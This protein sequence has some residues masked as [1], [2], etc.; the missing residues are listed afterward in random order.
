MSYSD[1]AALHEDTDFGRRVV[2]CAATE[3][4]D[5]PQTWANT[6]LWAVSAAPGFGDAYASA[7][8]SGVERP[9][10]DPAVITDAMILGAVQAIGGLE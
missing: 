7:L 4:A 2:A 10:N 5:N 1:V 9:G 8:A 3:G 6:N